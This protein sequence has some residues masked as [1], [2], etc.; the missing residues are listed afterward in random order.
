ME[1]EERQA[2]E[3][4]CVAKAA[5]HRGEDATRDAEAGARRT[6]RPHARARIFIE[7][8]S[9]PFASACPCSLPE[10]PAPDPR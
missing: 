5:D 7:G 2:T 8:S 4:P 10:L 6:D 1:S 9:G 3:Q